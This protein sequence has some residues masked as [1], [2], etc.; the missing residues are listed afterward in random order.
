MLENESVTELLWR[1]VCDLF[2][3]RSTSRVFF[4]SIYSYLQSRLWNKFLFSAVTPP[5]PLSLSLEVNKR[6]QRININLLTRIQ[7][8]IPKQR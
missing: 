8:G 7:L 2:S 3:Y 1:P 5:V 6:K 4:S